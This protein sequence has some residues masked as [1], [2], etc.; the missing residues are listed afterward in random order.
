MLRA[1]GGAPKDKLT[2]VLCRCACARSSAPLCS[3]SSARLDGCRRVQG[4]HSHPA[5]SSVKASRFRPKPP[6]PKP[7]PQ[8]GGSFA[9]TLRSVLA[10]WDQSLHVRVLIH[11]LGPRWLAAKRNLCLRFS[12]LVEF[13][14]AATRSAGLDAPLAVLGS[15]ACR[16]AG[17]GVRTGSSRAGT[18]RPPRASASPEYRAHAGLQR[19]PAHPRCAPHG[20]PRCVIAG[21]SGNL[22]AAAEPG[23]SKL[24]Y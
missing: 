4:D 12:G 8:V 22:A 15:C 14:R 2:G 16:F 3:R 10:G 18:F 6:L 17:A 23:L 19:A 24:W 20:H 11:T 13:L 5:P 21:A 7:E 9:G 1:S